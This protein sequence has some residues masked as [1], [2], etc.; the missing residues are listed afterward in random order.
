MLVRLGREY[1]SA[2]LLQAAADTFEMNKGDLLKACIACTW[3]VLVRASH[4]KHSL[5]KTRTSRPE[6]LAPVPVPAPRLAE[7]VTYVC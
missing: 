5:A 2:Q 1:W 4:V 3:M 7:V 6:N